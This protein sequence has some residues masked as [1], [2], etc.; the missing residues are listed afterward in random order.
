MER[1][2][3][4]D[5]D[6][7]VNTLFVSGDKRTASRTIPLVSHQVLPLT[8]YLPDRNT[9]TEKPVPYL[10]NQLYHYLKASGK[11]ENRHCLRAS[12]ITNWLQHHNLRQVQ[13]L[14][15]HK[16]ISSTER[17]QH[18]QPQALQ[19]VVNRYHPLQ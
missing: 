18:T 9:L 10:L 2:Q 5:I 4:A 14:A 7:E 15:G 8:H 3:I 19:Q 6:L 17:Y 13:Y 16:Y 11:V 1:I 12:V